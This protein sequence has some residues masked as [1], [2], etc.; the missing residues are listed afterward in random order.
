MSQMYRI[1]TFNIR[2]ASSEDGVNI[3]E[4]RA[5]AVGE[6]IQKS[7]ASIV[8]LQ[9]ALNFQL[10]YI[11][12]YL[13]GWPRLGVGRDDGAGGGEHCAILY[14]PQ[15][16]QWSENGTFWLSETPNEPGSISWN[17]SLP[18]I[19]TWAKMRSQEYDFEVYVLNTHL[20]HK[21]AMARKNSAKLIKKFIEN[22]SPEI[23]VILA[24]DFNESLHG[25]ALK[26]LQN[27]NFLKPAWTTV[28]PQVKK[29]GTFHNFL[30]MKN[31]VVIDHILI[32]KY[33]DICGCE[34]DRQQ[35]QNRYP[36]D[37]FP[38]I[39]SFAT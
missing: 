5:D 17:S 11:Q 39:L 22:L 23:P 16:W 28:H 2:Y 13:G 10:D 24:G 29:P 30:G 8:L 33:V 4:K 21:S 37:H 26:E 15:K 34:I 6:I 36:S 35:Y 3:W 32:N 27:E 31:G 12:Q 9:E 18:R 38:L 19:C 7:Q 25:E 1:M 20:D 14:N